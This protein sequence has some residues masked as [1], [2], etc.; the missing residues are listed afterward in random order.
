[1]SH[2]ELTTPPEDSRNNEG[3]RYL[4][5]ASRICA[6]VFVIFG[7]YCIVRIYLS[8]PGGTVRVLYE[9]AHTVDTRGF[10]IACKPPIRRLWRNAEIAI[11]IGDRWNLTPGLTEIELA[12]GDRVRIEVA[13]VAADG[14][15]YREIAG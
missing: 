10:V 2:T 14:Q 5:R 11:E 3:T 6:L 15:V 13:L 4:T 8:W 12:G 9:G 1:M 7:S